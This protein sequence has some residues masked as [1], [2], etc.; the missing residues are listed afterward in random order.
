MKGAIKRLLRKEKKYLSTSLK[1]DSAKVKKTKTKSLSL[2]HSVIAHHLEEDIKI[3]AKSR[4]RVVTF[5]PLPAFL[6]SFLSLFV[7]H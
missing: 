5:N 7:R 6:T 1:N 3:G 2:L 4:D